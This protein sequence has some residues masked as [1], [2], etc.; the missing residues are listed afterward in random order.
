MLFFMLFFIFISLWG[1]RSYLCVEHEQK[2]QDVFF[3][4]GVRPFKS[5]NSLS[6][7][8]FADNFSLYVCLDFR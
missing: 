8:V 2:S 4:S 7:D 6:C 5:A 3:V 1:R